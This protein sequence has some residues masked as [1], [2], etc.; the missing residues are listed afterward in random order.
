M[1]I[2]LKEEMETLLI[3]LY[4]RAQMSR[5][6]IFKDPDAEHAIS[7][8]DYDFSKLHVQDKTQ[9]M[10]SIRASQI[11][12]YTTEYLKNHPDSTVIYL[13][14]GLDAR[15]KRLNFPS[16]LWYDLDFPQVIEIKKQLYEETTNYRY[17]MSSVKD[18]DWMDKIEL[19]NKTVLVIAEG[20]LMYLHEQDIKLLFIKMRDK[21]KDINFIF[22]A[23]STLTAKQ[24]KNHPSLKK[25]GA[26]IHWGIDSP[27]TIESYGSGISYI[28]TIYLTDGNAIQ[29]L[30][31]RYHIIFRMADI[32]KVAKE[33]HRIF[34]MKLAAPLE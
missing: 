26:T 27:E 20:L 25:T 21:F 16:K 12:E 17:I 18:W 33:A 24:A 29:H 9:M 30:P 7:Q 22:D 11:D 28:K 10:L 14:C 34:V 19:N 23:Y 4:G 15:A 1:K 6:G 8:V 3:P 2:S 31:S 5:K 13:G 32:F